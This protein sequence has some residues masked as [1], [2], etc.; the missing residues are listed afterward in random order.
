M[1]GQIKFDCNFT[2]HDTPNQRSGDGSGNAK[3][4]HQPNRQEFN[5]VNPTQIISGQQQML[6]SQ[7]HHSL[8]SNTNDSSNLTYQSGQ[9]S[10]HN[11]NLAFQQS[12]LHRAASFPNHP[13]STAAN[14]SG[15]N[16]VPIYNTLSTTAGDN[17]AVGSSSM[18][19]SMLLASEAIPTRAPLV[20]SHANQ[21]ASN[22]LPSQPS[23]ITE[24][25]MLMMS[26][27]ANNLYLSHAS[28]GPQGQ[29][30][31]IATVPFS[32]NFPSTAANIDNDNNADYF[33]GEDGFIQVVDKID[34]LLN[35][36]P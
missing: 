29:R 33:T 15:F 30:G 13:L 14:L 24:E 28:F 25:E 36:K 6:R 4:Q 34:D 35:G 19:S 1:V 8:L 11:P 23:Q 21:R 5:Q 7:S 9:A 18:T 20:T 12:H 2:Y 3:G 27:F 10:Q 31:S 17:S 26:S 16:N 32:P 22:F